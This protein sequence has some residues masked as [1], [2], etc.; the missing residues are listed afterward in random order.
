MVLPVWTTSEEE[1]KKRS[2]L[3]SPLVRYRLDIEASQQTS[4]LQSLSHSCQLEHDYDLLYPLSQSFGDGRQIRGSDWVCS[5]AGRNGRDDYCSE[6]YSAN[7][8]DED[9]LFGHR[10]YRHIQ[11]RE[12]YYGASYASSKP[13]SNRTFH[14]TLE[15]EIDFDRDFPVFQLPPRPLRLVSYDECKPE[16]TEH[17]DEKPKVKKSSQFQSCGSLKHVKTAHRHDFRSNS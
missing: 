11:C 5:I 8:D 4:V 17:W 15:H 12:R 2:V 16:D 9:D 13:E 1:I 7:E 14:D 3:I 10:H 6:Y